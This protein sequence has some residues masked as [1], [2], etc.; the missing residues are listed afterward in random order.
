MAADEKRGSVG[1]HQRS[2]RRLAGASP[3]KK[4]YSAVEKVQIAEVMLA[5]KNEF[6]D[7]SEWLFNMS[8]VLAIKRKSLKSFVNN[9][10][11][12]KEI[13]SSLKLGKGTGAS[14]CVQKGS[15]PSTASMKK[16]KY[17]QGV[18]AVG[19]GR[20]DV[21]QWAK[22]EVKNWLELER[23]YGHRVYKNH[24]WLYFRFVL[25]QKVKDIK[26]KSSNDATSAEKDLLELILSRFQ[27]WKDSPGYVKSS[28]RELLRFTGGKV[29]QPNKV[30]NLSFAEE[31]RRVELT[32]QDFDRAIALAGL[33]SLDQLKE[34]VVDP[35]RFIQHREQAVVCFSD[36]IPFWVKI[37]STKQVFSESELNSRRLA[38]KVQEGKAN[39]VEERFRSR[40]I[41]FSEFSCYCDPFNYLGSFKQH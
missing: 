39:Q 27:K 22:V 25:F 20:K 17:S 23:S 26:A 41:C 7:E 32:W 33:G 15:R 12:N 30:C 35:L 14:K 21:L 1:I 28:R 40:A 29:L 34:H 13:V 11:K 37:N 31:K 8:K 3:L 18:R 19:A 38:A 5:N 16:R 2:N 4:E 6:K 10:A 36:Q 24:L 9:V